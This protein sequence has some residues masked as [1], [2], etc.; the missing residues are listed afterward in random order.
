MQNKRWGFTLLLCAFVLS[1]C[2]GSVPLTAKNRASTQSI[3]VSEHVTMPDVMFYRGPEYALG[4][5]KVPVEYIEKSIG[6]VIQQLLR[7]H[8]ID[9]AQMV[10]D[11]F[12]KGLEDQRLFNSIVTEGGDAELKLTIRIYG[13][14]YEMSSQ[15]KPMLGV[16]GTLITSNDTVLWKKYGYV[17]NLSKETPPN[18][19]GQFIDNPK[20]M[21]EAF[22]VATQIVVEDLITH[23][24]MQ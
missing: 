5:L 3:S 11:Q 14:G 18:T 20:L 1:A 2:V 6:E 23:M 21:R 4:A 7:E 22:A 17:T 15:L 10:R 12:I 9:V 19:L 16:E 8:K 24:R 13:F